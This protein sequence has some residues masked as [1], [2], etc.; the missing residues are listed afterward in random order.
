MLERFGYRVLLAVDGAEAVKLYTSRRNEIAVVITD[1]SMPVMDGPATIA[2]LQSHQPERQNHRL[3]R[4][5][6]TD[7][8]R[9]GAVNIP[10]ALSFAKPYTAETVLNMLHDVLR[11]NPAK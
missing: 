7:G 1:M 2:A 4:L 6:M 11:E 5:D 3:Q 9:A 10:K 8:R